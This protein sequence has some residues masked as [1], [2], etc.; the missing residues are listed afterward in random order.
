MVAR[1]V[2]VTTIGTWTLRGSNDL[3]NP[4]DGALVC[5]TGPP[6]V[7]IKVDGGG[8]AGG[9]DSGAAKALDKL[10]KCASLCSR[11]R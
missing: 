4:D 10:V 5:R 6:S 11:S 8:G 2:C 3:F 1:I 7:P 9:N